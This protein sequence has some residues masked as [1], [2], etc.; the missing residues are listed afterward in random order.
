MNFR[1][2][3]V[4]II[5]SVL[6]TAHQ[7]HAQQLTLN[8]LEKIC[9]YKN[10]ES[11]NAFLLN[12]DWEYF[13]SEKGDTESY[14]EITWAYERDAYSNKAQAWLH[15]YTYE[16]M[17]SKIRY[18]I[19]DKNAY[20]R[21]QNTIIN[22]GY[23][24]KESS[25]E[26]DVLASSYYNGTFLLDVR[27]TKRESEESYGKTLT[28]YT[29]ILARSKGIYD[30]DNGK[31]VE[32]NSNGSIDYEYTLKDGRLNGAFMTYH[33]NGAKKKTGS[34]LSD[35][36]SGKF[37]E[38]DEY[39][40]L[41][42]EYS[43]FQDE[44]NGTFRTYNDDGL[45]FTQVQYE[46]GEMHGE[47]L[48]LYYDENGALAYSNKG[49]Y[50]RGAK[51][52]DFILSVIEDGQPRTIQKYSYINGLLNG[53]AREINGDSL[54]YSNYYDGN[55]N[56][57]Y[58]VYTDFLQILFG[59][60]IL[61]DSTDLVLTSIGEYKEGLKKGIWRNYDMTGI[62]I[63][64]GSYIS[65]EKSGVWKAYYPKSLDKNS[66]VLDYS[67]ELYLT[68]TYK[69]GMLNGEKRRMSFLESKKI[70][71]VPNE[72]SGSQPID[73][74]EIMEYSRVDVRWTYIDNALNGPYILRDSSGTLFYKGQ[75][76]NNQRTG[77]WYETYPAED[78]EA[79]TA[80]FH[81]EGNYLKDKK[82]GKWRQFNTS[83]QLELLVNYIKGELD[84]VSVYDEHARL[85]RTSKF[86]NGK[87]KELVVFD[88]DGVRIAERYKLTNKNPFML[89]FQRI[90]YNSDGSISQEYKL[91]KEE[92]EIIFSFFDGYF[93]EARSNSYKVER[94]FAEKDGKYKKVDKSGRIMIEGKYVADVKSSDWT[95]YY[96]K[97]EVKVILKYSDSYEKL[98]G[99]HYL[100]IGNGPFKG[101]DPN[102]SGEF[103]Y[104]DLES[105]TKEIRK[106]KDGLRNGKTVI[107]DI[108]TEEVIRK[109][110]YKDGVLM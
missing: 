75:Y 89:E 21:I 15:L 45:L 35:Q 84:E 105:G 40:N 36:E 4:F 65:D 29:F 85:N 19:L 46:N 92:G 38:Y 82:H 8:E 61:E 70:L 71:C 2:S 72:N 9:D 31:K 81:M 27:T 60:I 110:K 64:E 96:H 100:A 53:K 3:I 76:K 48:S 7:V 88:D 97:Q 104:V 91:Y 67:G 50:T 1:R 102:F 33:A 26:D 101:D 93:D 5:T 54:I 6:I 83:G 25:I 44:L 30:P 37:E 39:G 68:E 62:L 103:E 55:L 32:Y 109:E 99:E 49:S 14:N 73:T 47:S 51:N 13:E 11:V 57:E 28:G 98:L 80:N 24:L 79:S 56:G 94:P 41:T 58:R 16:G 42:A 95:Y 106:I 59:G 74:C 77:E 69:N 63:A 10:W 78:Y 22:R 20:K 17:P 43:K 23:N 34:Y 87:F 108:S 86:L 18:F 12:K 107:I 52:G 90:Q 66:D